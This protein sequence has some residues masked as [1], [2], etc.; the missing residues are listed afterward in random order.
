MNETI[1]EQIDL[2]TPAFIAEF[3]ITDN[4]NSTIVTGQNVAQYLKY[5]YGDY[6]TRAALLV[7]WQTYTEIHGADFLKAWAAWNAEYN[8]IDNYNGTET[9]VFLTNDGEETE[10]ITHGKTT[11]TTLVGEIFKRSGRKTSVVGNIGDPV[12]AE[13]VKAG[14]RIS[15]SISKQHDMLTTDTLLP[16]GRTQGLHSRVDLADTLD[17]Q[18]TQQRD[19]STENPTADQGIVTGTVVVKVRQ[20]Q[21]IGHDIQLEFIELG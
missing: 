13:A 17:T 12:V 21:G 9:N 19:Q 2:Y 5:T 7:L 3:A 8:P 16:M 4:D 18:F 1:K 15:V 14:E 6:K 20:A 11:T 10:T